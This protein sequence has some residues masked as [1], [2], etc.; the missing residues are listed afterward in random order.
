MA[1][2]PALSLWSV[3]DRGCAVRADERV[4][5]GAFLHLGQMPGQDLHPCCCGPFSAYSG[6]PLDRAQAAARRAGVDVEWIHAGLLEASLGD[7]VFDLV[8][9]QYPAL[10]VPPNTLSS[11]PWRSVDTCS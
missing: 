10:L 5:D 7:R 2:D 6:R 1:L 11:P 3:D 4:R 9:V 8:S